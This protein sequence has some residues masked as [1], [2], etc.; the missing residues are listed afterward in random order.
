MPGQAYAD[1]PKANRGSKHR[2]P[3]MSLQL[4]SAGFGNNSLI[5]RRYTCE[6]DDVSP[7]LSWSGLPGA[8]KSLALIVDDPDA[9]DPAAP[10][11]TWVHWVLYDIPKESLGLVEDVGGRGLPKGTHEGHN[12]WKKPGYRGP[13]PP[14][15]RHRYFFRL[16]ALDCVLGD[17]GTCTKRDLLEAMRGHVLEQAEL[18][19]L[20]EKAAN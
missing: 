19:G 4:T 17:L 10:K 7:P 12:D 6:G 9:P 8:T 2:D 3:A 20:Y 16:Y 1:G 15:G 11:R 14:V 18:V 5:P 13:C